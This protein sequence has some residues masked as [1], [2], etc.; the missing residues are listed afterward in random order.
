MWSTGSD[1]DVAHQLVELRDLRCQRQEALKER[2][3]KEK[4]DTKTGENPGSLVDQG[5][6]AC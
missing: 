6:L 3:L 4:R 5:M 2:A 1:V